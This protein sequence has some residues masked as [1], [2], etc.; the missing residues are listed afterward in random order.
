VR[1]RDGTRIAGRAV[2]FNGDPRALATGL[3]G[4]AASA[5]ASQTERAERSLSANVW[6]F[7]AQASGLPLLHHNVFFC[8]DPVAEFDDLKAGR[9]PRDPTI[10]LCAEDRGHATKAA[11]DL[12]RFEII[13]N[14]PPL[15]DSTVPLQE[16]QPCPTQCFETLARFGLT[17]TPT[18]NASAVTTPKG[19]GQLFPGSAGSLYGQSPHGLMAAFQRPTARTPIKGLYLAG[20]GTHPGA[21]V[22]MATLSARHAAEAIMTDHASTSTFRPMATPGGTLME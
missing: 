22:P 17:L 20:G 12:E 6:A 8:A 9:L 10:Y 3:L 7:A 19:F 4:Q 2:L 13:T 18:P 11:P 14:A 5:A 16:T 21:G 1:L 15:S